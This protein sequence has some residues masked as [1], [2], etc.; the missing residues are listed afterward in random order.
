MAAIGIPKQRLLALIL[1]CVLLFWGASSFPTRWDSEYFAVNNS[2]TSFAVGAMIQYLLI[3]VCLYLMAVYS[4]RLVTGGMNAA[5]FTLLAGWCLL[6]TL[7]TVEFKPTL[8]AAAGICII[9]I[10]MS[11]V[12]SE[13]EEAIISRIVAVYL[14]V[15]CVIAIA[16]GLMLPQYG[17]MN[18]AKFAG[19]LRG[20]Y[21]HKNLL[22]DTVSLLTIWVMCAMFAGVLRGWLGIAAIAIGCLT[23][24]WT[25]S[26]TS[27][28]SLMICGGLLALL[29]LLARMRVGPIAATALIVGLI[30]LALIVVPLV[31]DEIL[32][33]FGKDITLTGRDT[34]WKAYMNL[35]AERPLQGFGYRALVN[36]QTYGISIR[37]PNGGRP[38]AHNSFIT[39]YADLGAPAVIVYIVGN[40]LLILKG[41]RKI[42]L[43]VR[44]GLFAAVFPVGYAINSFTEGVGGVAASF[45]FMM[46]VYMASRPTWAPAGSP[47]RVP[48]LEAAA[49]PDFEGDD[50]FITGDAR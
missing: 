10:T 50:D 12:A 3:P 24:A 17:L 21:S 27:I 9:I 33:A 18:T 25:F 44:S 37:F 40:I 46:L 42:G 29:G 20:M 19:L 43:G 22:G 30:G 13:I 26:V 38:S 16:L 36:S 34:I 45:G 48:L 31:A 4:R 8:F 28:M 47:G 14:I 41:V 49:M 11:F 6:T 23:V 15:L 1:F 7:W 32:G 5:A 39:M 35:A 2:G